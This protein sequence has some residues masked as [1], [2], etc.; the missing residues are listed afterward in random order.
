MDASADYRTDLDGG[1]A[2]MHARLGFPRW[3]GSLSGLRLSSLRVSSCGSDVWSACELR[4]CERKAL[5]IESGR[6]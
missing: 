3:R 5:N 2:C 6:C 4:R 1:D